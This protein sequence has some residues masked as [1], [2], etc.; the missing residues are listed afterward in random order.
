MSLKKEIILDLQELLVLSETQALKDCLSYVK[1]GSFDKEIESFDG[2]VAGATDY[3]INL[4][5]YN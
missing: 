3:L 1:D 4:C 5:N 2:T